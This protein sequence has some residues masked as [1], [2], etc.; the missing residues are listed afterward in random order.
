M[1]ESI[2]QKKK[3]V[4]GISRKSVAVSY[5]AASQ[6]FLP[7]LRGHIDFGLISHVTRND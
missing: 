2:K 6:G 4:S 5:C 3:T 7:G 1:P